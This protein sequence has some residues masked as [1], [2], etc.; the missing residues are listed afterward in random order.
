M[1]ELARPATVAS[2]EITTKPS[3]AVFLQIEGCTSS[4]IATPP[5]PTEN[6]LF[7]YLAGF[8]SRFSTLVSFVQRVKK[9]CF[10]K[11]CGVFYIHVSFGRCLSYP[12]HFNALYLCCVNQVPHAF[13][14]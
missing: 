14:F 8:L 7:P 5:R 13:S 12:T 10:E 2:P 1:N 9:R 4:K 3:T 6:S 11:C